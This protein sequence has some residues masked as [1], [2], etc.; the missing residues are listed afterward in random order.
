M[1]R[2][3]LDANVVAS[4]VLRYDSATT[5]PTEI[6]RAWYADVFNAVLSDALRAEIADT[7]L[8]KPYFAER[9]PSTVAER[10]LR[11]IDR[12]ADSTAITTDVTKVATHPEDDLILATA[13]SGFADY[14]VT[15]DRQ[16]QR[17][18]S[19]QGVEIV[20]PAE[21]LTVLSDART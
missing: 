6:L 21:F 3:V 14:L 12:K 11:R 4:A 19:F 13:V 2:A 17:L 16:L 1:I 10:W 18:R 8:I 9:I 20:S 7:L 15:G 5:A